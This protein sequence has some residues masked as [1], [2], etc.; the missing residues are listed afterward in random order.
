MAL[1]Q[2][3]GANN[4]DIERSRCVAELLRQ[5]SCRPF[6]RIDLQ[7]STMPSDALY[8]KHHDVDEAEPS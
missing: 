8:L 7:T 4:I 2:M 3:D 1:E 6:V 5:A